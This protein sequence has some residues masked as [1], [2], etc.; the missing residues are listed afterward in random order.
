MP[1][2]KQDAHRAL[3]LLEEYR[4]RL[5]GT[6][7]QALRDALSKAIV[8]IRAKL[9]QALLDIHEFYT[10]TL[11]DSNKSADV[12]TQETLQLAERWEGHT[13]PIPAEVTVYVQ[14]TLSPVVSPRNGPDEAD[15]SKAL[16]R[17]EEATVKADGMKRRTPAEGEV[18]LTVVL[19]K[20]VCVL[21]V[22]VA[23]GV[24]NPHTEGQTGIFITKILPDTVAEQDGRLRL[25]DQIVSVNG[26]CLEEVN[27]SRAVDALKQAGQHVTL[28]IRRQD[29]REWTPVLT[30]DR[31]TVQHVE[32]PSPARTASPAPPVS[33]SPIRATSPVRVVD[34]TLVKNAQGLGFSI[35]GGCGNQHVLGD[36]GIFITRIISGGAADENG[37]LAVGDRILEVNGN[38]MVSITHDDAVRILKS[39]Q[40]KVML[41]IEKNAISSM[42]AVSPVPS[43]TAPAKG[44]AVR[45][46]MLNRPEGTGLGFNI[47]GGEAGTGIFISLISPNGVADKSSQLKVGD[48]ILE[49]NN[50]DLRTATHE[51]AATALKN[52]GT[53][54]TLRV[55][56]RP[57]D[58]SD[59]Q[60]KLRRS[61]EE[62]PSSPVPATAQGTSSSP[63][64]KPAVVKQLYVRA[65]FDYD[66]S[67]D[68]DRPTQ[69]LSF[70]HGDILH[71]LNGSDEEWWQ[72]AAVNSQAVDGAAG[73]V[74]SKKRIERRAR[75]NQKNVKFTK[76]TEPPGL[77]RKTSGARRSSFKLSMKL[78]FIKKISETSVTSSAQQ[79]EPKSVEEEHIATYEPVRL[80]QRGY[81][82]PVIVLGP[83]K[84]EVNDMLVQ[85]FPDKFAG[86][87]PHTTRPPRAGEV[88]G[89]DYHFVQSVE[90]MEKDIQAHLFIEAGRYKDNLYGTSIKAVQEVAEQG[91]H[92]ILG[93]S[94]YAIRR[95]QM[96]DLHPIA[97]CIRPNTWEVI[98]AVTKTNQDQCQQTLEKGAKIEQEFVE[99]FTAVVSGDSVNDIYASV[100][101]VI[102]DQSGT[103]IWVPTNEPLP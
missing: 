96:A 30:L 19:D 70:K 72:A 60:N 47:I 6:D 97:I 82:R 103:H 77:D 3:E 27:H 29:G 11:E 46:V 42:G 16:S 83:L 85:E 91:K 22:S 90:Q 25:G 21:G 100:K 84:E 26:V 61:Q 53:V 18:E 28:V 76:S 15:S 51:E 38:S 59:F 12:K 36:D 75:A 35:A 93:V 98:H 50:Q 95:L 33:T 102:Q 56:Y 9:F 63:S 24:D 65:L 78:P 87:V 99:Y 23:G 101:N 40:E 54:V 64:L 17:G 94:G 37:T 49:V 57:E 41:R 88:D 2:R 39:T 86:C 4:K 31:R 13:S 7:N 73:L 45:T 52:A 5:S 1:V 67:K 8:A 69:G 58:F 79:E 14:K 44:I 48:Q 74:P 34:I 32:A 55:E 62:A 68:D 92:C 20:G 89:K 43:T 81:A 66:A 80:E 10:I 71:I